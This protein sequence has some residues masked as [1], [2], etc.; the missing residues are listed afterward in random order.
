MIILGFSPFPVFD[1]YPMTL[2]FLPLDVAFPH[3][4]GYWA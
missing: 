1:F 4:Q 2:Q 3:A